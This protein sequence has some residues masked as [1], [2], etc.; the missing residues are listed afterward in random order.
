MLQPETNMPR[1]TRFL[2]AAEL[3]SRWG[4]RIVG[5][6]LVGLMLLFLVG[7]GVPRLSSLGLNLGPMFLAE[8]LC[9]TGFVVLWRWE[10]P[11]GV[12]ALLGI[13]AFY[14]LNYAASGRFPGGWVFPLFFVPGILAFTAGLLA[15]LCHVPR[16]HAESAAKAA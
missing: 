6:L 4:A 1:T 16:P 10:L 15:R 8:L 14:G 9:L 7:E 5:A 13:T 12:L 2:A 3:G 11:G